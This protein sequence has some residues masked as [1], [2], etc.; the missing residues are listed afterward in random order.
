MELSNTLYLYVFVVLLGFSSLVGPLITFI[1]EPKNKAYAFLGI[2]GIIAGP[3]WAISCVAFLMAETLS[4]AHFWAEIIYLA[5]ILIGLFHFLFST[6]YLSKKKP[7]IWLTL[8][9]IV[10]FS[11]LFYEIFYTD[12]FIGKIILDGNNYIEVGRVYL[13]WILWLT[14]VFSRNIIITLQSY[15]KLSFIEKE[16]QK[17]LIIGN[18][19]TTIGSFPANIIAPY[20]GIYEYI[21]FGPV[22]FAV[23]NLI[24]SYGLTQI[25]FQRVEKIIRGALRVIS[26][27]ILPSILVVLLVQVLSPVVRGWLSS[28]FVFYF[29]I[30][31]LA[32]L[33]KLTERFVSDIFLSEKQ[34]L[35]NKREGF[36]GLLNFEQK[37]ENICDKTLGYIC[38]NTSALNVQI[39]L[40]DTINMRSYGF[41]KGEWDIKNIS[42]LFVEL[43]LFW[44][45]WTM[46]GGR[47]KP[48]L[49]S[50]LEYL[51][52]KDNLQYREFSGLLYLLEISKIQIVYPIISGKDLVGVLL[53]KDLP[54]AQMYMVDELDLLDSIYAQF[55]VSVN[56]A[57]LYNQLQSFNQTLQQKVDLQTKELQVKILELQ[58]ARQKETDMI[59]I[60][61]HEL[62]TPATIV[63]LNAQLLD[64]FDKEI[65]SDPQ[66]YKRYVDRIK[67][68]VENEI[69]LINTLLSSAKLEGD[70]IV[71]EPEEINIR[72]E[73]EMAIHG[74]E[75]EAK[76]KN[77]PIINNVDQ[78]TPNVFA[79]KARVV[80]VLNN[81]V[82]NGVKYTDTGSV[83]V[84]STY[85]EAEV[86]IT[87]AD[88]GK[89]ISK[90][91]LPKL[92]QKFYRVSNYTE[93]SD[94]GRVD[95]VR[96]GGTGL[97]L[98][99]TFNL[100]R[101][102][103]GDVRVESELGKGSKFIFTLPRYNGQKD[104]FH[105]TQSNDM[106]E[107]LGL[108]K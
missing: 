5:S 91:D 107:K 61:G 3:V 45:S 97:G 32:L 60:M 12:N 56:K 77:L 79:D 33:L 93:S 103:G 2:L 1:R 70:K 75:R 86:E 71:I 22:V 69:K 88:T 100:I 28:P 67:I 8:F 106:F 64:K 90:E 65:D 20:F 17:Y 35:R 66:A 95:I 23:A 37:L 39:F 36:V 38:S 108:K 25:R 83:T 99:V 85:N 102:M 31:L 47:I 81:L 72:E 80:E 41:K 63:K 76:D 15:K 44:N 82:S 59:D 53:I 98:F 24:I 78:N 74:N 73:I 7:S 40:Y 18:V 58:E 57:L 105:K 4:V 11:F 26:I 19:L 55:H 30:F 21:W 50:E 104:G 10:G 89:G 52:G 13:F 51:K 49:R 42:K 34:I 16:Q 87:V 68:A 9:V 92:G 96:P 54:N 94:S 27:Y 6:Y 101:K 29:V 14:I 46:D 43:P 48:L 84:S 62:R